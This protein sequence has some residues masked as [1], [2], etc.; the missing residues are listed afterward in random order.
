[1]MRLPRTTL[2]LIV[3]GGALVAHALPAEA[4]SSAKGCDALEVLAE[5]LGALGDI[6]TDSANPTV[7]E[8]EA[9][10]RG[11]AEAYHKAAKNA[12]KKLRSALETLG[13][14]YEAIQDD[15]YGSDTGAKAVKF[16]ASK[17]YTK[18]LKKYRTYRLEKCESP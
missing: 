14:N 16:F 5:D 17:R 1:M 12:P 9:T 15:V 6:P 2:A 3:A 10:Y 8:L 11:Q 18:A 4:A 7:K 13:D